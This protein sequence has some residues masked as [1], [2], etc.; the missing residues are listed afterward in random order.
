M[1]RSLW[2]LVATVV[3]VGVLFVA[4]F[5]YHTYLQQ[6]HNL[7]QA[8]QQLDSLS[9]QDKALESKIARLQTNSQVEQLARSAYHL[10]K[11]GE[12]AYTILPQAAAPPPAHPAT[13]RA[14]SPTKSVHRSLWQRIASE[15]S[16]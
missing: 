6:R 4:G 7:A 5:P 11:P 3:L 12:Q 16:F 2:A 14:S 15:F 13:R 8:S 10:V 1:S 9:R